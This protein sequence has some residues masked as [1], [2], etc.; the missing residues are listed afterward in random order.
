MTQRKLQGEAIFSSGTRAIALE[1]RNSWA[2]EASLDF[3][4]WA[5]HF[6][7][8]FPEYLYFQDLFRKEKKS[9]FR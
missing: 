9:C 6:G 1:F 2:N 3:N 7:L 4:F 8:D 5:V